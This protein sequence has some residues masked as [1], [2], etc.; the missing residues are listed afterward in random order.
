MTNDQIEAIYKS[1]VGVNRLAALRVVYNAGY[2]AGA[3]ITVSD[4]T[5]DFSATQTA[6]TVY[7]KARHSDK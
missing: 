2:A 6:P 5:P 3:S 1:A 7:P 4:A